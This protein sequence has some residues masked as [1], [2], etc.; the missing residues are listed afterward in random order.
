MYILCAQD[1]VRSL[2]VERLH[3]AELTEKNSDIQS[4]LNIK[5]IKIDEMEKHL[6][7]I[8]KKYPELQQKVCI[9]LHMYVFMCF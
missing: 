4:H 8:R 9:Y 7:L 5:Q 3:N 6:K 2:E 1:L